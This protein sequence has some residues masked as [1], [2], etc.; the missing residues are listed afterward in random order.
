GGVGCIGSCSSSLVP[1]PPVATTLTAPLFTT[2]SR[3]ATPT[4]HLRAISSPPG[5]GAPP[6]KISSPPGSGAPP[7]KISSPPGRYATPLRASSASPAS[8]LP[9][10]LE[11][12]DCA[13]PDCAFGSY[14]HHL[15]FWPGLPMNCT[16]SRVS[17]RWRP[18]GRVDRG[19]EVR[20]ATAQ[21][22]SARAG[23][24]FPTCRG[25]RMQSS[26]GV[27]LP[28]ARAPV[29]WC[30][31]GFFSGGFPCMMVWFGTLLLRVA[32]DQTTH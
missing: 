24:G 25:R 7:H 13:P 5:S 10:H 31:L 30:R 16:W 4:G 11:R 32:P 29:S 9:L 15:A 2:R 23:P 1:P 6:H 21:F 12:A 8:P 3:L 26:P 18:L 20:N 17:A 28:F 19:V 22:N 27:R 14:P